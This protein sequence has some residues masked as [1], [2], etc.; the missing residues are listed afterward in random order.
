MIQ[1]LLFALFT[2]ISHAAPGPTTSINLISRDQSVNNSIGNALDL[3]YWTDCEDGGDLESA[4]ATLFLSLNL[5]INFANGIPDGSTVYFC[6]LSIRKMGF[7]TNYDC[8][9]CQ[10]TLNTT[11]DSDPDPS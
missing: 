5:K 3:T 8:G 7:A 6:A 2:I 1:T 10:H 11:L 4:S 9:L